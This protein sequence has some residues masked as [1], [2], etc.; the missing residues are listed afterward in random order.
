M[1]A[2]MDKDDYR[3]MKQA[4]QKALAGKLSSFLKS[5]IETKAGMQSLTDHYRISGF[6]G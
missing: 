3:E 1:A 5:A 4:E 2:R 6:Y